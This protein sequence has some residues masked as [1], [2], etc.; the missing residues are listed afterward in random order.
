MISKIRKVNPS[1]EIILVTSMFANPLWHNFQVHN[2]YAKVCASLQTKGVAVADVRAVH[3]RL[4]K[5]KRFIDMTG[6]N[7]NHPNDFL[8]RIYAQTILQKLIPT[9]SK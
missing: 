4:L 8:I 5:Q 1:A 3:E 6:N 9:M 7:V 2:E